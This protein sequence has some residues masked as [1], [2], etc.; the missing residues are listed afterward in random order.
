MKRLVMAGFSLVLVGLACGRT[1]PRTLDL[2]PSPTV[3]PTQTER[4]VVWTS[5]PV[6]TYTPLVKIITETPS[7]KYLCVSA[8]E[9]VHLRPSPGIDNYPIEVLKNGSKVMDLGGRDGDWGF[10]SYGSEQGWISLKYLET[11]K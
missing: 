3:L 10:F 2:Y 4:I 11:C 6:Q 5:T 9:A 7:P 1:T 8:D